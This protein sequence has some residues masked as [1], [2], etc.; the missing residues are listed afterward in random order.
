MAMPMA[1]KKMT[2]L[3]R[4]EA[5]KNQRLRL[6]GTVIFD[7]TSN[8]SKITYA[9]LMAAS[10]LACGALTSQ[11]SRVEVVPGVVVTSQPTTKIF[12]TKSGTIK[13]LVARE[14]EKV[15]IGQLLAVV[16]V[17]Y[18]AEHG[19]RVAEESL[20]ALSRQ[21]SAILSQQGSASL[22]IDQEKNRLQQLLNQSY[23]EAK[24]LTSQ[25]DLQSQLVESATYLYDLSKKV[26]DEG[27]VSK[28]EHERRRQI[29][30]Q[31]SQKLYQFRQQR[32]ASLTQQRQFKIQMEKAVIDHRKQMAE[33]DGMLNLLEQQ[34]TKLR[35][36]V[37]Y[38]VISLA[39]GRA[40]AIQISE[41]QRVESNIP[42][43]TIVPEEGS[44][45]VDAYAPSRAIGFLEKGQSVRIMYDA[46]P[47]QRFGSFEGLVDEIS[48][49]VSLPTELDVPLQ[50]REA[51]YRVRITVPE[52]SIKTRGATYPLKS[53]MTLKASIILEKRSFLD[54]FLEPIQA[55]RARS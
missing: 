49:A 53:G 18:T 34:R 13:K 1:P 39:Q 38:N 28:N 52:Q 48:R 50:L 16:S 46:F 44:F 36:E 40:T 47:Y 20:L 17:D 15:E 35:A 27:I 10:I 24:N 2:S 12:A 30:I 32:D 26:V 8:H 6:H 3:F 37:D 41:G 23:Q 9:I 22:A 54:K 51:A 29:K 45:K 4:E 42:V 21:K 43:M 31:E 5:L 7:D 55:M 14:N 25:I 33:Y 19:M 11:Y